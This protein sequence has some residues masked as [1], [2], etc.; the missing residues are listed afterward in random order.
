MSFYR[1]ALLVAV[2]LGAACAQD[3]ISAKSGMIHYTE[4][5]VTLDGVEVV[6]KNSA[7]FPAM[8][9]GAE[10]KTT[11][12]RAEVL[13]SPGVFMRVAENSGVRLVKN[14]ILDTQLGITGGSLLIEVSE[15]EKNSA[16]SVAVGETKLD[17]GRRGLYRIDFSPAQV[18]VY[19]GSALAVAGGQ[20]VTVKEGKEATLNTA[21]IVQSKFDKEETDAFYRWASRR[22]GYIASANLSAAKRTYD[23]GTSMAYSNWMYNPYFGMFTYMPYRGLYHSPFGYS[24]FSPGA[25]ANVFYRPVYNSPSSGGFGGGGMDAG[26]GMSD[27]GGR[28]SGGSYSS[29]STMSAPAVSSAPAAAA[30]GARGGDG[31][32]GGGGRG[33][34]GGR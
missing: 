27:M 28:S 8:K 18:R 20:T 1:A 14:D 6:K 15:A 33:A 31:G 10:L 23:N 32:G 34:G 2:S 24:Y 5:V 12:G 17:L 19:N 7:D 25:V 26:R 21:V 22:S 29:G 4:G 3:V 9:E 11:M 30:A 16:L 13:L